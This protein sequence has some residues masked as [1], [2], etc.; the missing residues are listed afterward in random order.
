[1]TSSERAFAGKTAIV[2]GGAS[3]IGKAMGAELVTSGAHVVLADLDGAAAERSAREIAAAGTPAGGSVLGCEVDVRD[4][5]AVRALVEEIAS[6]RNGLDLMF[7]NAGITL[8]GQTHEM[9]PAHWDRMIDVNLR[10]VV[11]GVLAAYPAMVARGNGQIVN[12]A[13]GLGLV[14]STLVVAY[15]ATKHA[16]VGLS[17]ALRPEAARHGVG[18]SVLC[19]GAVDTPILDNGPPPDLPPL[20]SAVM[21][22]R[23]YLTTVGL[24]PMTADRFAQRALH[25]VA[26]NKAIIVAPRS[27]KAMWYLH[28]LS[29]GV[30]DH[31]GRM[32]ARR[33]LAKLARRER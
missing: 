6:V 3:G 22:G 10:G 20:A 31:I 33:V 4:L 23:E 18:V 27:A 17:T 11:N 1:M 9:Q 21:T 2:T 15:A 12:T 19:P 24:R 25:D 29:P 16:V 32:T 26:R 30:T 28:R 14:P 13:S 7:N 8:G 5:A